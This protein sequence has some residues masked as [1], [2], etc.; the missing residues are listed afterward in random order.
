LAALLLRAADGLAVFAEAVRLAAA[1]FAAA[2]LDV[3][4]AAAAPAEATTEET[5]AKP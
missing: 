5:T 3:V 2:G 4:L 1:G